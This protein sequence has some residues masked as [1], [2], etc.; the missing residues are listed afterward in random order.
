MAKILSSSV[1]TELPVTCREWVSI[2]YG[3]HFCYIVTTLTVE[4]LFQ[5]ASAALTAARRNVAKA[6]NSFRRKGRDYHHRFVFALL[7]FLSIS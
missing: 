7:N 5:G 1:A 3:T 2:G 4:C 6:G